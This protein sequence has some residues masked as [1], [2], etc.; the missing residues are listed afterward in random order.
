MV[1]IDIGETT[2]EMSVVC[3]DTRGDTRWGHSIKVQPLECVSRSW[4]HD[5]GQTTDYNV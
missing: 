5:T 4:T 2:G 3:K 1:W